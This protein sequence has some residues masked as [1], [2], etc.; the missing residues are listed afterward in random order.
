MVSSPILHSDMY[1]PEFLGAHLPV[2]SAAGSVSAVGLFPKGK[3]IYIQPM[4]AG[5]W[6]RALRD[7]G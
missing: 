3:F 7:E 4:G 6:F 1:I 5:T 2:L